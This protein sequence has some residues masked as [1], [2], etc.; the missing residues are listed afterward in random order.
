[1]NTWKYIDIENIFEWLKS[2]EIDKKLRYFLRDSG[3]SFY[4]QNLDFV[5]EAAVW[6]CGV[7]GIPI[8]VRNNIWFL[9]NTNI[10]V[11]DIIKESW[12]MKAF[13]G[14]MS[15]LNSSNNSISNMLNILN[16][17]WHTSTEH[18]IFFNILVSWISTSVANEFN[19][20]R[21]IIHLSRITEARTGVQV[22]PPYVVLDERMLHVYKKVRQYIIQ[23]IQE[24]SSESKKPDFYESSNL[25]HSSAKATGIILSWSLKNYKKLAAMKDDKWKELEFRKA[26]DL[27]DG[28]LDWV[29]K[30]LST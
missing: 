27:I 15:Y 1:M 7:G 30:I 16:I 5:K 10:L 2:I 24:L 19:S 17:H 4:D 26:L 14:Y 21:D 25:L 18:M 8:Q 29:Y 23:E 28:L 3:V 22:A 12:K 11:D 20:Q 9:S 13:W 6:I